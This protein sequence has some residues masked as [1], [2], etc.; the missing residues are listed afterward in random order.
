MFLCF[1][2]SSY[3]KIDLSLLNISSLFSSSQGSFSIEIRCSEYL[4]LTSRCQHWFPFLAE[5]CCWNPLQADKYLYTW[6]PDLIAFCKR[7]PCRSRSRC[8]PHYIVFFFC[9]PGRCP[10]QS[11]HL[12]KNISSMLGCAQKDWC[13]ASLGC[14]MNRGGR[15]GLLA[16]REH[17]TLLNLRC[18]LVLLVELFILFDFILYFELCT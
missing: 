14:W 5:I 10:S 8:V 16:V 17:V 13:A 4:T 18:Q 3:C 6:L 7:G 11:P 15:G 12:N 9:Y 2:F 1:N